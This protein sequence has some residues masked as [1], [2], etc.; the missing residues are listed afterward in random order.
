MLE[1]KMEVSQKLKISLKSSFLKT[2]YHNTT[3]FKFWKTDLGSSQSILN[4][5]THKQKKMKN[6]KISR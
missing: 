2:K 4:L 5:L 3:M 6:F 1:K